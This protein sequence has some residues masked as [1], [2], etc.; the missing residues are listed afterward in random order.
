LAT[1]I[2]L[3]YCADGNARFAEIAIKA[4]FTYGARLPNT[5]YFQP[6]FVDQEWEYPNFERYMAALAQRR[7]RLATVLDLERWGQLARVIW[8]A[9]IAAQ[10]VTEAIIII[11][12][13]PGIVKYLPTNIGNVPVRLGFSWPTGYG[14]A[15]WGI[16]YEMVDWPNGIH[17]LGGSPICVFLLSLGILKLPY[18]KA[19][20]D[21]LLRGL[22]I[23][24]ADG[25]MHQKMAIKYNAFFDPLKQTK[26]GY[27]PTLE[28]F[29]GQKW[30]DGSDKSDA[31]YEAFRRSCEAIMAMWRGTHVF[32]NQPRLFS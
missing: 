28:E 21:P 13:V 10:Y 4:E 16:L 26:R 24:S 25:N 19:Y 11:P 1:D 32:A 8:W 3:I 7:P 12:K 17:I 14:K 9:V 23:V 5:V 18:R 15:D 6:D 29:D 30:G 31:P 20:R 27:W 2:E 22:S